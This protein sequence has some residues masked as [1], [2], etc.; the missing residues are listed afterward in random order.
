MTTDNTQQPAWKGM[1]PQSRIAIM[2]LVVVAVVAF[3]LGGMMFGGGDATESADGHGQ[4]A[5]ESARTVRKIAAFQSV[6]SL[7]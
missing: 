7:A 6:A 1:V 5:A 3:L 4:A 2:L